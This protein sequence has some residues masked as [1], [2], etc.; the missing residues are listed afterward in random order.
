LLSAIDAERG[1]G[2]EGQSFFSDWFT[3]LH[4]I[5]VDTIAKAFE[6]S[7]DGDELLLPSSISLESHR[8]VLQSIHSRE[9][10]DPGLVE[11]NRF[12]V[13]SMPFDQGQ[14]FPA[15][16]LKFGLD[17][18]RIQLGR[19]GHAPRS[20]QQKT[21]VHPTVC[22]TKASKPSTS[23]RANSD[24]LRSAYLLYFF[25]FLHF[26]I[27]QMVPFDRKKLWSFGLLTVKSN[28][29]DMPGKIKAGKPAGASLDFP[30]LTFLKAL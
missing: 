19:V 14:N 8:L 6:G 10:A 7:I 20:R 4:T 23:P 30:F 5:A 29:S 27:D 25:I 15:P 13:V 16:F 11:L 3:T 22:L 18:L 21:T 17:A 2:I 12:P 9:A 28:S 24:H 26:L 1:A